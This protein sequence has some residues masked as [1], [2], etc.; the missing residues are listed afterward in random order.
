M[1]H[2]LIYSVFGWWCAIQ[3][4]LFLVPSFQRINWV[5]NFVANVWEGRE[6][7]HWKQSFNLQLWDWTHEEDFWSG[8]GIFVA[9]LKLGASGIAVWW[10]SWRLNFDLVGAEHHPSTYPAT[11]IYNGALYFQSLRSLAGPWES[12]VIYDEVMG[13]LFM[14]CGLLLFLWRNR[15]LHF[16]VFRQFATSRSI[17]CVM[18]DSL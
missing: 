5:V 13:G 1:H 8:I 18:S 4:W 9:F 12:M 16:C 7:F 15:H 11:W 17:S 2:L 3:D 10:W 6:W 14:M